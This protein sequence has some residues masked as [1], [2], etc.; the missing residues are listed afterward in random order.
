MNTGKGHYLREHDEGF[1]RNIVVSDALNDALDN[2]R[3]HR[4]SH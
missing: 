1:A 3:S 2:I 4:A